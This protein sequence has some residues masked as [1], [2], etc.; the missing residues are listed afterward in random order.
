MRA[1]ILTP[2]RAPIDR[3]TLQEA[4]SLL[5][6]EHVHEVFI[7]F[8]SNNSND[9]F[10]IDHYPI[11]FQPI[12]DNSL[13]NP[14]GVFRIEDVF[15][16]FKYAC[17]PFIAPVYV[18]YLALIKT[19]RLVFLRIL[20]YT[21]SLILF[22]NS[23]S[24]SLL[25]SNLGLRFP[26]CIRSRPLYYKFSVSMCQKALSFKR[27]FVSIV[28]LFR[29][30]FV[31]TVL[32]IKLFSASIIILLK[33]FLLLVG[34]LPF[35]VQKL[36]HSLLLK[37]SSSSS[38]SVICELFFLV[39]S[40]LLVHVFPFSSIRYV[41]C[42]M[43][44]YEANLLAYAVYYDADLIIASDLPTLRSGV[45][46]SWSLDI[47]LIY[48]AHE[49]YYVIDTL[50]RLWMLKYS[51]RE[52][53]F[54]RFV[55]KLLTVSDGI[56]DYY[57]RRYKSTSVSCIPNLLS[58]DYLANSDD[59]LKRSELMNLLSLPDS[60]KLLV[61]HGWLSSTRGLQ[62]LLDISSFL[63]ENITLLLIGYADDSDLS[64]INKSLQAHG[65]TNNLRY[66]PRVEQSILLSY[67][68]HCS[69]G[70]IPYNGEQDMNCIHCYPNKFSELVLA[71]VPIVASS[72]LIN[73]SNLI[74]KYSVGIVFD[75]GS[76]QYVADSISS[77]ICGS[78]YHSAKVNTGRFA[79]LFTWENVECKFLAEIGF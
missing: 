79:S 22:L 74:S 13:V 30:L 77:Y 25:S 34:L 32:L 50:P 67:L 61:F 1:V 35:F 72:S 42:F 3:R 76:P 45:L 12:S 23:Y 29:R 52:Y 11:Y 65:G 31:S 8:A 78:E 70:I 46:A 18:L 39:Y 57:R 6:S 5:K 7:L 64:L 21:R 36:L 40:W 43:T 41:S 68:R 26:S 44:D 58:V 20:D 54:S 71:N 38:L 75:F 55:D 53:L 9:H 48:D 66:L 37:F 17:A 49:I 56:V 24:S 4:K 62:L 2:D 73:V 63:P 28:I 16:S 59:C 60:S 10:V 19:S 51:V 14:Y 15:T 33:R 47:D 69:L 27:F